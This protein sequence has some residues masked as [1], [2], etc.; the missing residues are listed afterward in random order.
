MR[1]VGGIGRR[2]FG[3]KS[4]AAMRR[5]CPKCGAAPFHQC[6]R[7]QRADGVQWKQLNK[8]PHPER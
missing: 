4:G 5:T 2:V 1:E 6:F 8:R 7:W 3:V